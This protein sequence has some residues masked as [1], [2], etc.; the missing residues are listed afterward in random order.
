PLT[1][2]F[3]HILVEAGFDKGR[4]HVTW[5][6]H[7]KDEEEGIRN[8]IPSLEVKKAFGVLVSPAPLTSRLGRLLPNLNVS[9]SEYLQQTTLRDPDAP[10][11]REEAK[12][13]QR[14][15]LVVRKKVLEKLDLWRTVN[16]GMRIEHSAQK[17]R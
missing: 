5:I 13:S 7:E 11:G 4:E 12:M 17:R 14:V 1:K 3:R 2:L 9:A 10:A 16:C 15:V 8:Q 6:A